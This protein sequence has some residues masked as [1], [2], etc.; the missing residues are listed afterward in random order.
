VPAL[1][2]NVLIIV[3]DAGLAFEDP[4]PVIVGVERV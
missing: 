4:H 1:D 2:N 3:L